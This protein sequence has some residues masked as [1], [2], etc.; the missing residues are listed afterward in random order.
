MG[1]PLLGAPLQPLGIVELLG[2][3]NATSG[4]HTR[5]APRPK[6]FLVK[7]ATTTLP[8][9]LE[10]PEKPQGHHFRK[11]T[12]TTQSHR[13]SRPAAT[14][15][16]S[17]L[18][19]LREIIRTR[20]SSVRGTHPAKTASPLAPQGTLAHHP[21]D[22][23]WPQRSNPAPCGSGN[24]HLLDCEM[25]GG[26][27]SSSSPWGILP[28]GWKLTSSSSRATTVRN[29]C[30][31]PNTGRP[32]SLLFIHQEAL[33]SSLRGPPNSLLSIHINTSATKPRLFSKALQCTPPGGNGSAKGS[34]LTP[35]PGE[36]EREPP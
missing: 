1:A 21:F 13:Y 10:V 25:D 20:G 15:Q 2:V 7:N 35:T 30:R 23:V 36:E 5:G 22:D 11:Y 9:K 16:I 18:L 19:L 26:L 6:G 27:S 3:K 24:H 31:R 29:L 4:C 28:M 17:W 34:G 12:T 32:G 33:S 14:K 8:P